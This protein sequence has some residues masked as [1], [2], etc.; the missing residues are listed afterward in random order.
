MRYHNLAYA[1]G[2]K[3]YTITIP[4]GSANPEVDI[5]K[6]GPRQWYL[7]RELSIN[8]NDTVTWINNDT[9]AHTV[10]SGIGGGMESLINTKKL[11]IQT[12]IFNSGLFKPGQSWIHTFSRPGTYNYFCTIHPWMEGIIQVKA[13]PQNIPNYPVTDSG[14]RIDKL[15]LYTFTP[16]GMLEV[17]LSWDPQV[18]L[19]G[20]EATIFVSFFDRANNKPNLLSFDFV[21]IQNGKQ[22]ERIPTSAQMGMKVQQYV[23]A[24]SGPT[25]IRIE[26]IGGI[27]TSYAAFNTTVYDNPAIPSSSASQLASQYAKALRESGSFQIS[28]LTLVYIEYIIIF[29]IPAAVGVTYFLYRKGII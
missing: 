4:K 21:L 28:P 18:L 3:H 7:P 14:K 22:L 27:K 20:K 26:N 25:N 24:N 15:P 9:E 11:G 8:L 16:D 19:T 6:L 29:G 2:A 17:G 10:T 1:A 23:F 13:Q 5:T 12:G